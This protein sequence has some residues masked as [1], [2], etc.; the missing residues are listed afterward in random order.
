MYNKYAL[1][2]GASE[3]LGKFLA[4]ECAKRKMNL[5]LVALPGS[6]LH[7]LDNYLA[8][9]FHVKVLCIETDLSEESN[10]NLLYEK[11]K[12]EKISISVLINNAGMGGTFS[13]DE[14][15]SCYYSK[16]ISLNVTAPTLLCRLFLEDLKK[17]SPSY[18]LNVG[19]LAGMFDF[20]KKQVYGGTKS[21]LL[22]FSRSLRRDLKKDGVSVSN[23][24]PGGMN[25]SWRLTMENRM[26]RTWISRQSI[27]E[28]SDV[29]AIGIRKMLQGKEL[30][31]TGFWNRFLL[32]LNRAFPKRIKEEL[33]NYQA[34]RWR[35]NE[36]LTPAF[37]HHFIT[38][39]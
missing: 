35:P 34:A 38:A 11:V 23:L 8:R 31:I 15:E 30:I 1:I 16:L 20:A 22:S 14:R 26:M 32:F 9:T 33:M 21:Y 24:S 17:N 3:G 28:P 37:Q 12:S 39:K 25:T 10:C 29:A 18:I 19:S 7:C 27:M 4:I 13:F 5:V 2:T 36:I 6:G